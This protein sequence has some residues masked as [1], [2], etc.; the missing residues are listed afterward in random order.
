MGLERRVR[1]SLG[2]W[3]LD[4]RL[5]DRR[6][7]DP[8]PF[9]IA[10]KGARYSDESHI[11]SSP[12]PARTRRHGR[13]KP[14]KRRLARNEIVPDVIRGGF[15]R[16]DG[17]MA[18]PPDELLENLSVRLLASLG[19]RF[20]RHWLVEAHGERRVLRRWGPQPVES[21]RYEVS[22]LER[23]SAMGWPVAPLDEPIEFDGGLWSLAPFLSGEFPAAGH[24]HEPVARGRLLAEFH[25]VTAR[26]DGLGERPG[27]RRCEAI[28]ADPEID[29]LLTER[30]AA[31]LE[32]AGIVRWHLDRAR[33]RAEGLRL[34]ERTSIPV[35]GDFAPWNLR[36]ESER[37]TGLLDFELARP[38]HR[39]ADFALA[40]RG[41]YDAVIEG[42]EQVSPLE[43]EERAA[44]VPVWWAELIEGF[45]RNLRQG[46]NDDGWTVNKLLTRS[47][48]MGPDAE[49][50]P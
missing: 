44:I 33:L 3:D 37:L 14:G 24:A 18:S 39:I 26:I 35:H 16:H 32:E 30:E 50:L 36:Y 34:A 6:R 43:P 9:E 25:A 4:V 28:L 1:P 49:A 19:G 29:R 11:A 42:Y 2:S 23:L 27:W 15:R 7:G 5:R 40:W 22:L 20:N 12:R 21:I 17:N 10:S 31:G 8:F 38:D 48:A 47:P 41:K 46:R 45:C 13:R